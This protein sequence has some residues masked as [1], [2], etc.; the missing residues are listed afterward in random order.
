MACNKIGTSTR[1]WADMNGLF[2]NHPAGTCM[3]NQIGVFRQEDDAALANGA[4][5]KYHL[6]RLENGSP[7]YYNDAPDQTSI[8]LSE[9]G[10]R[11]YLGYTFEGTHT[12][13]IDFE[14]NAAQIAWL[15][16]SAPGHIS[17]VET[18]PSGECSLNN[19]GGCPLKVYVWNSGV[20]KSRFS[21]Q[22]PFCSDTELPGVASSDILPV[23][24]VSHSIDPDK[25]TIF[26]LFFETILTE[27][28]NYTCVV[29]LL[30]SESRTTD[31]NIFSVATGDLER[32]G[33][34]QSPVI[35]APIVQVTQPKEVEGSLNLSLSSIFDAAGD[36]ACSGIT[37][38]GCFFLN[39]SGCISLVLKWILGI[40]GV[41][42]AT[43]IFF[44]IWPCISPCINS[45]IKSVILRHAS[46]APNKQLGLSTDKH[47]PRMSRG[48]QA[49]D[50][51]TSG[52]PRPSAPSSSVPNGKGVQSE[53]RRKHNVH[54]TMA[55]TD[56][57]ANRP[58]TPGV[59]FVERRRHGSAGPVAS[60]GAT[61]HRHVASRTPVLSPLPVRP[62]VN[63]HRGRSPHRTPTPKSRPMRHHSPK[64]SADPGNQF[65][66][67]ANRHMPA[68]YDESPRADH[69]HNRQETSRRNSGA[70]YVSPSGPGRMLAAG[71]STAQGGNRVAPPVAHRSPHGGP[72]RSAAS[73]N[74][75]RAHVRRPYREPTPP[76]LSDEDHPKHSHGQHHQ[77]RR[78]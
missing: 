77:G 4:P 59:P 1:M 13:G 32:L 3:G 63:S 41:I 37:D 35:I 9:S 44:L 15:R 6:K 17:Y 21:V 45:F 34:G 53:H 24:P 72:H 43:A 61:G 30:D 7:R 57:S 55:G 48:N 64:V 18:P 47:T 54:S 51:V 25:T 12:T 40:G 11:H 26:T 8:K 10:M 14:V 78:Y 31:E 76:D 49:H 46:T 52:R 68:H 27:G 65:A 33:Q 66:T 2:C 75:G 67:P 56:S 38:V 22:V 58:N 39:F 20:S 29:K 62:A 42:I 70:H 23:Q 74:Q 60:H 71:S 36:C 19:G 50:E 28:R 16:K 73:P 69:R 5:L